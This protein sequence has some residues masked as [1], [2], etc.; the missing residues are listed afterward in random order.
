MTE[1]DGD[2][3]LDEGYFGA[4]EAVVGGW[5]RH[6]GLV[7]KQEKKESGK[8]GKQNIYI[9]RQRQHSYFCTSEA[10]TC[11]PVKQVK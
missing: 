6:V 10:S 4:H 3:A 5:K 7:C 11:V 1:P 9:Y 2:Q 8:R